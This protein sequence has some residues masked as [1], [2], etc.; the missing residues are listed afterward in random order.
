M[1]RRHGG[2]RGCGGGHDGQGVMV[3][4]DMEVTEVVEE[5]AMDRVSW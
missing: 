4:R 2:D 3:R 1:V 5:D